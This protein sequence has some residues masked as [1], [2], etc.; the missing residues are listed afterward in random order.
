MARCFCGMDASPA[1]PTNARVSPSPRARAPLNAAA[2]SS[3]V[4]RTATCISW[5]RG[6]PTRPPDPRPS[7]NSAIESMLTRYGVTTAFD[8][9]SDLPNTVA[10]R[11]RIEKGE[12]RGPRIMTAGW[13]LYPLD[14]I[15]FYLRHLPKHVLDQLHQP[16]DAA[17]ARADV[18]AES[19]CAARWHEALHGHLAAARTC[20]RSLSAEVARAAVEGNSCA[21]QAGARA[22]HQPRRH[23][24]RAAGRRRRHRAHHAG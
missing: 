18:R 24:R 19:R 14:G 5:D 16:K 4:S 15:P 17:E 8:T 12:L 3:R 13:P 7:S 21:R 6:S 22:S 23:S 1:S 20:S 2:S 10:I 11:S 9:G